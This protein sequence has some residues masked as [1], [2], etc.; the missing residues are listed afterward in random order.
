MTARFG[1]ICTWLPGEEKRLRER[2]RDM[3]D[4]RLLRF[5]EIVIEELNHRKDGQVLLVVRKPD[6]CRSRSNRSS[7][8]DGA[9]C[10]AG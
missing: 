5:A 4:R 10:R 2:C 1:S 3:G 6:R 9:A 8:P 7:A